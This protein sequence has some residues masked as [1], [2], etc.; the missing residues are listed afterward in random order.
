MLG[1]WSEVWLV[2]DQGRPAPGRFNFELNAAPQPDSSD[3]PAQLCAELDALCARR[4]EAAAS[5]ALGAISI[6]I[7]PAVEDADL[8]LS[9][10]TD[11]ARY[12]TLNQQVQR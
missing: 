5:M 8:C 11:R 12:R 6:G 7:L 10:Q 3:G 2:D 1:L 9:N 4:R